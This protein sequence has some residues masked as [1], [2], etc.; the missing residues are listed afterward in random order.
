MENTFTKTFLTDLLGKALFKKGF[1]KKDDYSFNKDFI[2]EHKVF[3][4]GKTEA[5]NWLSLEFVSALFELDE[6]GHVNFRNMII[7]DLHL[8]EKVVKT[9]TNLKKPSKEKLL[10]ILDGALS[11]CKNND[12]VDGLL[13]LFVHEKLVYLDE[14]TMLDIKKGSMPKEEFEIMVDYYL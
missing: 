4:S 11:L 3:L 13:I 9:H 12:F 10:E 6:E 5:N 7:E 2:R 14:I 8:F 1:L